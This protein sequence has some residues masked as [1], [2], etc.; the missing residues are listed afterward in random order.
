MT[1]YKNDTIKYIDI[2]TIS[3]LPRPKSKASQLFWSDILHSGT[4][5]SSM[6]YLGTI[7]IFHKVVN[8][9]ITPVYIMF[10]I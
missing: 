2:Q 9:L 8:V 3:R 4:D 7:C 5:M 10:M 6:Y 1:K